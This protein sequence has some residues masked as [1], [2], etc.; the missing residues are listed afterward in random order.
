MT[1]GRHRNG[2]DPYVIGGLM[3]RTHSG[4]VPSVTI[5]QPTETVVKGWGQNPAVRPRSLS[6]LSRP[7]IKADW[8]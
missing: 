3:P 5:T 7:M 6:H 2:A 1:K 4:V 8:S